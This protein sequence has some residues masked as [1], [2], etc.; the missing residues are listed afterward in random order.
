MIC[1]SKTTNMTGKERERAKVTVMDK[2]TANSME[3]HMSK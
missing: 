2:A 3:K 1:L